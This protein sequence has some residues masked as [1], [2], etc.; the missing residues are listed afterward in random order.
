[1]HLRLVLVAAVVP[2]MGLPLLAADPLDA[3][4]ALRQEIDRV[5]SSTTVDAE[6]RLYRNAVVLVAAPDHAFSHTSAAGIGGLKGDVPMSPSHQFYVESIT[7]T[8]TAVIALQLAEEGRLGERGLDATLAELEI[9]PPEVLDQLHRIDGV[10][11]G[12]D[13]TVGQLVSHRTGMKNFTYEDAGGPGSEPN[14]FGLAPNSFLGVLVGDPEKGY[15][16]LM[17]CARGRLPEGKGFMESLVSQG[18]PIDCNPS[19]Y[20]FF[21]PPYAHWDYAAWR[22]DPKDRFAGLLNFYMS[23]MNETGESPPG[24]SFKYTDT[25][26]LVLGLVIEKVSG[27]SL[28]S[29]LRRRIFDPLVM[30]NSYMSYATDPP[31]GKWQRQLAELWALDGVPIVTLGINRSMMW[32][33]AGIVSTVGDLKKFVRALVDGD[34]F[35]SPATLDAMTH[36]PDGGE[37]GYGQGIGISRKG[38]DTTMFHTGGAASWWT[39]HTK[40]NLT[41]M[42]TMNDAT[43]GGRPRFGQVYAGVQAALKAHGIE[44]QSPF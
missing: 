15:A 7:K 2:L 19:S 42:G 25:N 26:Y 28:H 6:G 9:F 8:F 31:V 34:L 36:L 1:M 41:F 23:G 29:E 44:I 3:P 14:E 30:D 11:Y 27:N 40:A 24:E 38:G 18:I 5:V 37:M 33:D 43:D 39:H 17:Q 21:R 13:I 12:A 32:S 16:G 35:K 20:Y 22:K 10:S 4:Q